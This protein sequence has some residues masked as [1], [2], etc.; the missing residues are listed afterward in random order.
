MTTLQWVV[1]NAGFT[2]IYGGLFAFALIKERPSKVA[3]GFFAAVWF[4]LLVYQV[5]KV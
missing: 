3:Y 1:I 2:L 5:G 4:V